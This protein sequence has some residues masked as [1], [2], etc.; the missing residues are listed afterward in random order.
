MF[1]HVCQPIRITD[2]VGWLELRPEEKYQVDKAI[3]FAKILLCYGCQI[4]VVWV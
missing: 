2:R 1:D 4:L 3:Q